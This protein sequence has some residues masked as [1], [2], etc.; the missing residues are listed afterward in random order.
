[1]V[2]IVLIIATVVLFISC[3]GTRTVDTSKLPDTYQCTY[4]KDICKEAQEYERKY[5]TMTPEEKKEFENILKAYHS[6]CNDALEM[7]KKS[8]P[9]EDSA[10]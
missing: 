4:M 1:M 5:N 8:K 7:C 2:K 9:V 6:Q 10:K 3:A